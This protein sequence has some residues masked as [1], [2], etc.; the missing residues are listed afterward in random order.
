[1][2]KSYARGLH[3]AHRKFTLSF[4]SFF[5]NRFEAQLDMNECGGMKDKR[6][7]LE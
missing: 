2:A 5:H 6:E 4:I 3:K 1:M 7:E